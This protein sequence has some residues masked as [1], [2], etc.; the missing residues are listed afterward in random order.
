MLNEEETKA[1]I[2]FMLQSINDRIPEAVQQAIIEGIVT[3]AFILTEKNIDEVI[4]D[5]EALATTLLELIG[6]PFSM[7]PKNVNPVVPPEWLCSHGFVRAFDMWVHPRFMGLKAL[8][9]AGF[10]GPS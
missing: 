5:D 6:V 4:K 3:A 2:V 10:V 7:D 9:H 1:F 8:G